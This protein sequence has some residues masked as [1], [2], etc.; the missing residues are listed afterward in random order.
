MDPVELLIGLA[1]AGVFV[2]PALAWPTLGRAIVGLFFIAGTLVNTFFTLP[3]L[4][5]SLEALVATAPIAIY[6]DVVR[7][8]VD[9]RLDTVLV[10]LVII[11][12][13]AVGLLVL[14]RGPLVRLGLLG[15]AAW[16]LGMLPVVPPYGLPIG[17]ALTAAPGVAALLLA[18]GE[19]KQGVLNTAR[20]FG[21]GRGT[22][23]RARGAEAAT[24]PA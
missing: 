24:R 16:G 5:G 6:H 3:M 2:V 15:A 4:P 22:R 19:Y 14:W 11:F 13:L 12:E 8:A 1:I 9:W 10:A 20:L 23:Q 18:R 17:V 21:L 7:T